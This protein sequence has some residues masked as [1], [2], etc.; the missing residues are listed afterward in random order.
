MSGIYEAPE[1]ESVM[2][3]VRTI[4][5]DG[6]TLYTVLGAM[7][8]INNTRDKFGVARPI[9]LSGLSYHRSTTMFLKPS[10]RI[11]KNLFFT[12]D[13]LDAFI[14]ARGRRGV[15]KN[16]IRQY[17]G[18]R[19][20]RAVERGKQVR[21]ARERLGLSQAE[22]ADRANVSR[23]TLCYIETGK[24]RPFPKTIAAIAGVLGIDPSALA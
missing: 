13:D 4:V 6:V 19:D 22:L 20:E 7:E 16:T 17:A 2:S 8:Y 14:A 12:K 3:D 18:K 15:W 11:G 10:K 23:Q 24:E 5:V 1:I 21:K 9:T